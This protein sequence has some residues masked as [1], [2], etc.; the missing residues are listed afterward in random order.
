MQPQTLDDRK[1]TERKPQRKTS[2]N[3]DNSFG[4]R[5]CPPPQDEELKPT[6]AG[7]P[8]PPKDR[9][10]RRFPL[11]TEPVTSPIPAASKRTCPPPVRSV[12]VDTASRAFWPLIRGLT[13]PW[14]SCHGPPLLLPPS[15]PQLAVVGYK[16]CKSRCWRSGR[17][18][19]PSCEP[20]V[21]LVAAARDISHE[22]A[23]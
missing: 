23:G 19:T 6:C 17:M 5:T 4:G 7:L 15:L 22:R 9:R 18:G 1:P 10:R 13:G 14:G 3:P 11:E 21:L 20:E 2:L 16:I 12:R 8:N